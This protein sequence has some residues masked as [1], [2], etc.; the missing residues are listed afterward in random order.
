MGFNEPEHKD[1]ANMSV[2]QAISLW[3]KLQPTEMR[4]DSPA[5]AGTASRSG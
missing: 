2:D 4:I 3:L 1:Q 5:P